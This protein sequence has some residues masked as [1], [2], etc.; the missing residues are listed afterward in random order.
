MS[1]T[2]NSYDYEQQRR[3]NVSILHFAGIATGIYP[4]GY[5]KDVFA[6]NQEVDK[7]M[8]IRNEILAN[9]DLITQHAKENISNL[10]EEDLALAAKFR[11]FIHGDFFMVS[12][13]KKHTLFLSDDNLVYGVHALGDP[14][15]AFYHP[16][17][18]PV[19]VRALLFPFKDKIIYDGLLEGYN[20]RFGRNMSASIKQSCQEVKAKYGV[21]TTL[22]F[23]A[24]EKSAQEKDEELLTFY[25]KNAKN[26][27]YY[28]Y[29]IDELLERNHDLLPLYYRECGKIHARSRKKTLKRIEVKKRHFAIVDDTII[30]SGKTPKEVRQQV[31]EILNDEAQTWVHYFKI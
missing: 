14:F 21:I 1:A 13:L 6:V 20:M 16:R 4:K 25:M 22:P 31:E 10:N 19:R 30:A 15:E 28:E 8:E 26:R 18:L 9:P 7:K 5:P 12:Y 17:D 29:E 3:I 23:R 2:L 27:S 11:H 24:E